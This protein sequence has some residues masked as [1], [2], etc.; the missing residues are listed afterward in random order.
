M[1]L[2][3][4]FISLFST[5]GPLII[6]LSF[7]IAILIF[8]IFIYKKNS[9]KYGLYLMISSIIS[10]VS[11]VIIIAINYPYLGYTLQAVYGFPSSTV[12][13]IL[14]ILSLFFLVLGVSSKIL[15]FL[16][17]YLIYKTHRPH[18]DI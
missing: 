12:A 17:I 7:D 9:Y 2:Q 1:I 18:R 8:A 3:I 6:F 5:Y 15:L 4:P 14:S 10:I 11:N 13:I 16:A